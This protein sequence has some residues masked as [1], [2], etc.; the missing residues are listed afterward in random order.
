MQYEYYSEGVCKYLARLY[1][2]CSWHKKATL[3]KAH[4]KWWIFLRIMIYSVRTQDKNG[5]L[6]NAQTSRGLTGLSWLVYTIRW[7][8]GRVQHFWETRPGWC[9]EGLGGGSWL[10]YHATLSLPCFS[11]WSKICKIIPILLHLCHKIIYLLETIGSPR[12]ERWR[13]VR[14]YDSWTLTMIEVQLCQLT[15]N[16]VRGDDDWSSER[17]SSIQLPQPAS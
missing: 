10:L 9:K 11:R 12:G 17:H 6:N 2:N 5:R 7:H 3:P 13:D 15:V 8:G 1:L 4:T 16:K 14:R